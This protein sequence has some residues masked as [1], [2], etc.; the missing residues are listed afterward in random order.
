MSKNQD[1]IVNSFF[2]KFAESAAPQLVSLVVSVILARLLSPADY[3]NISV[4]MIFVTIANVFVND[5]LGSALIQKKNADALDFSSVL[6]AN[7]AFSVLLYGLV[8]VAAPAIS[9][10]YGP[11]YEGLCEVLRVLGLRIVLVGIN[12]VQ[13]AYISKKMQFR[14]LFG[15][16]LLST[17]ISAA[18]GIGMA[19]GG[20]GVWALVVQ[21]LANALISTVYLCFSIHRLP[22]LKISFERLKGLLDYGFKILGANLMITGY[23]ELRAVIIGKLYS[24]QDL[25][26]YDRGKQFPS[27]IVTNINTTLSAVLFPRMAMDQDNLEEVTRITRY[28]I[29]MC[30]YIMCPLMLGLASV[31]ESFVV[32]VLTEKWLPCVP[33]LQMFC[34]VYLFQPIHLANL[35]AIKAIGRSD[36]Y[37]KLEII[38]KAIELIS[39]LAVMWISVDAI[40]INMAVLTALFTVVNAYPNNKLLNYKFWDQ[41]KDMSSPLLM[42]VL[43]MLVVFAIGCLSIPALP[44]LFIQVASGAV[45]YLLLSIVTQNAEFVTIIDII[46]GF[47]KR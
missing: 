46:K 30:S 9:D 31:A 23:Q 47:L 3:G 19:V 29:R 8:F 42:S 12:S 1:S 43:M 26:F 34:I 38:K 14:K 11:G 18:V 15:A 4:V 37:L 5:G 33:L 28:S 21:N 20:Y 45:V 40:V 36:I 16:T 17:I 6:Y 27:L 10:F 39:L 13:Q 41:I 22:L 25:A 7:M 24:A 35:Q 2:W 32:V 44:M